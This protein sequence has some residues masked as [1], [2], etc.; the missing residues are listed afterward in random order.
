MAPTSTFEFLPLGAIIQS[1]FL[2][3]KKGPVNIVQGFPTTA[4]YQAYNAPFFG[5]TIGRVANRIEKATIKSLNGKSYQ[6]AG[7]DRG[8]SLH[9]G[10]VGW[11]KKIWEG[12]TNLGAK[13]LDLG[14][15]GGGKVE[16]Q[17]IK[18]TL[19]SED[20]DEGYPGTVLASVIYT[21]GTQKNEQGKDVQVLEMEY[22]VELL[23]GA[24]E[25]VVN[26]TNHS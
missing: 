19:K 12:P 1:F 17:S 15:D 23:D 18:F 24:E 3:T 7:N 11:G 16:G 20:G 13:T 26:L 25:T 8:N 5:E 6:L 22:E 9:G 21:T 10:A 14:S 4:L 2:P